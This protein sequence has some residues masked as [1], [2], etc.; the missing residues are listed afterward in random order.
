M[1]SKVCGPRVGHLTPAIRAMPS[2]LAKVPIGN[3]VLGPLFFLF[4][5]VGPEVDGAL[6]MPRLALDLDGLTS[7]RV[8]PLSVE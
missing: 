4:F 6:E 2:L 8:L 1:P 3:F 5:R 7:E